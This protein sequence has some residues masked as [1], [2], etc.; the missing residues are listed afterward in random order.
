[1]KRAHQHRQQNGVQIGTEIARKIPC[2][3]KPQLSLRTKKSIPTKKKKKRKHKRVRLPDVWCSTLFLWKKKTCNA[4]ETTYRIW[5]LLP[6]PRLFRS[7][8][9][10]TR[11]CQEWRGYPRL[12]QT[13]SQMSQSWSSGTFCKLHVLPEEPD[14]GKTRN[15]S[16]ILH[17]ILRRLECISLDSLGF[18]SEALLCFMYF[19]SWSSFARH[20]SGLTKI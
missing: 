17:K 15:F 14:H 7:T 11:P 3:L 4:K 12:A 10:Q 9:L 18:C 16:K 2:Y 6:N 13:Q 8:C 20:A 5:C 19:K 1:M